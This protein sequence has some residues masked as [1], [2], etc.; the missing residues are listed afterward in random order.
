MQLY[1]LLGTSSKSIR[2]LDIWNPQANFYSLLRI[3]LGTVTA[4]M[5]PGMSYILTLFYPPHRTGKRIGMYYTAAQLSAAVVSLVSAGFQKMNG[6][7]GLRGYEWMF[8][9][10]GLV[11]IVTGLSLLWWLPDRPLAPGDPEPKYGWFERALNKVL[12]RPTPALKGADREL[13]FED[14]KQAYHPRPWGVRDLMKICLDWRI[15]PLILMYFGVVGVGI[16]TQI[17]GTLI[18]RSAWSGLTSIQ[19]S[20]LFAPIWLADLAA[21][22]IVMPISDYFHTKRPHVFICS[23]LIQITGLLTTT[24]APVPRARYGGLI[25]L[26]FGLGPTVPITMAWTNTVFQPRHGEVG[27]AAATALVSGLGNLGSVVTTY[28]LYTGW[29]KDNEKGPRQYRMSNLTM[30]GMLCMSIVAAAGMGIAVWLV[31]G[32]TKREEETR[33]VEGETAETS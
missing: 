5:W 31:D 26:G 20:L 8:L 1:R 3:L 18:I 10:Y 12:P 30:V 13:H 11:G 6:L 23:V 21:I 22:L 27:V 4:G 15:W 24:F 14:L 9:M 33:P 25:M 16:G 32:K 28:A 2:V 29:A 19:L 17:F 7:G